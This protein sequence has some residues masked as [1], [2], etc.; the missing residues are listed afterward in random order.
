MPDRQHVSQCCFVCTCS[1]AVTLAECKVFTLWRAEDEPKEE[2]V[3]SGSGEVD[4]ELWLFMEICFKVELNGI[5]PPLMGC[6]KKKK[7]VTRST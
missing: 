7:G 1:G 5:V 2:E 6:I 4:V 3:N